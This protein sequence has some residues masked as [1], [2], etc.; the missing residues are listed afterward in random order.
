MK[1]FLILALLGLAACGADGPPA[2]P[3][4]GVGVGTNVGNV[5]VGAGVTSGV[6]TGGSFSLGLSL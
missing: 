2:R 5:G 6:T 4:V 3:T 1:P